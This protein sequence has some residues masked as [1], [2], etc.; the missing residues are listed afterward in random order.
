VSDAED[1]YDE[2]SRYYL[3]DADQAG[4]TIHVD[5]CF[6]CGAVVLDRARHDNHHD[7]LNHLLL[8]GTQ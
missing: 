7:L 6:D 4:I 3:H 2:F 5:L 1:R 8:G